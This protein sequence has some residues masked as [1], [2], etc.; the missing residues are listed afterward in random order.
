MGGNISGLSLKE[1]AIKYGRGSDEYKAAKKE[2]LGL[3][4]KTNI[5]IEKI[6]KEKS[7]WTIENN[8]HL[9]KALGV[10]LDGFRIDQPLEGE[11]GVAFKFRA[12]DINSKEDYFTDRIIKYAEQKIGRVLNKLKNKGLH[13]GSGSLHGD[14]TQR[15]TILA[16]HYKVV[17]GV[18]EARGPADW[19]KI[20]GGGDKWRQAYYTIIKSGRNQKNYKAPSE[21][22]RKKVLDILVEFPEA[23]KVA[24]NDFDSY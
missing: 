4:K 13:A 3:A 23:L 5:Y 8:R 24:E 12:E 2:Y 15:E 20:N 14:A 11:A 9:E 10:K 1:V 21:K 16:H 19:K 7:E 6:I 17:A 22:E 18:A